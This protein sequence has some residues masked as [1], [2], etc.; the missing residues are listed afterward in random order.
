MELRSAT[1]RRQDE[2]RELGKSAGKH[3]A[4]DKVVKH[5]KNK[6]CLDDHEREAFEKGLKEGRG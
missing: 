3:G 2:A 6:H 1:K 5:L 4:S